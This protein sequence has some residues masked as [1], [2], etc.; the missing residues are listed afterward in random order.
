MY[1]KNAHLSQQGNI[2]RQTQIPGQ[3][4][5]SRWE[6]ITTEGSIFKHTHEE[7]AGQYSPEA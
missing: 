2:G 4:F 3:K 7:T 1:P 5:F 6:A